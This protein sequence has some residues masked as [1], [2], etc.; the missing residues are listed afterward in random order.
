MKTVFVQFDLEFW[1][2]KLYLLRGLIETGS[3]NFYIAPFKQLITCCFF[4][5]SAHSFS[6]QYP[7][8]GNVRLGFIRN[9]IIENKM[10]TLLFND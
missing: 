5:K 10:N 1:L 3:T 6:R 2:N 8:N 4:F 9:Y 7:T